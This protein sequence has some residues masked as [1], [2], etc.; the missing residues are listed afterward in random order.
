[1]GGV[2]VESLHLLR[3]SGSKKASAHVI[4]ILK[5]QLEREVSSFLPLAAARREPE[6][7]V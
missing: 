1:M 6:A 5:A 2:F 4:V 7:S 3:D